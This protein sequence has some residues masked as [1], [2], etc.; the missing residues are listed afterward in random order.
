MVTHSIYFQAAEGSTRAEFDITGEEGGAVSVT[1][2]FNPRV[3]FDAEV[4][5]NADAAADAIEALVRE[6]FGK[7]QY[8]IVIHHDPVIV[9]QSMLSRF[10]APLFWQDTGERG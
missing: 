5:P 9:T 4:Y 10:G 7:G 3:E 1:G 6:Q 8:R 2:R